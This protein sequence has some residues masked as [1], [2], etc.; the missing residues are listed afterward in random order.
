MGGG[1]GGSVYIGIRYALLCRL[2]QTYR[3]HLVIIH[4]FKY[5]VKY[6]FLD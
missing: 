6:K 4:T 1:G 5:E 2:I 3:K